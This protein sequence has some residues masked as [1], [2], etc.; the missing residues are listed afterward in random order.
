M[1]RNLFYGWII[2][3]A[4]III[5]FL[6]TGL[7]GY[8]N[9][10]L[11]PHLADTLA[12]GSRGQIS[13]GISIASIFSALVAPLIGRYADNN[14][15]R[16][17]LLIGAVLIVISY[18]GIASSQ[19]LWHYYVSM[20]IIFGVGVSCAGPT[21]RSLVVSLWFERWRGRALGISVMGA[22]LAGVLL[23]LILNELVN[24]LGWRSTVY[25]CA[26]TVASILLPTIYFVIKDQPRDIGEVRD[27][28]KNALS[29]DVINESDRADDHTEVTWS[30]MLQN[31]SFWAIGLIFGPMTCVYIAIS[32][33]FF[34]HATNSGLQSGQAAFVLSA[35]A[36]LSVL[37]KPFM[38]IL[39]DYVGARITIWASLLLQCVGLITFT[40]SSELWHFLIA[41]CFHGLGYAA[42]S[43][44]R[45]FAL[46]TSIG[47]RSL[48]SSVGLLKWLEL[49]FAA[50]A[51]PLAGFVYD[52]TGSYDAAFLVFAGLLLVA[53]LGPFFIRDG[54]IRNTAP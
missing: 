46:S 30:G 40:M 51:S 26:I 54:R 11:L 2:V 7:N 20:G 53:C 16:K 13:I 19:K 52:A 6:T 36:F 8:A 33:H 22:S 1:F 12:N 37:G 18:I 5:G 34:G 49:P 43:A 3:G 32:V 23:P 31:K 29:A 35:M 27:G 42:M 17:I 28:H 41:A 15:P 21:V 14:S 4:A 48:G 24:D 45:T 10:I 47:T 9:G 38:G 25:I 50:S 39:A 44:M